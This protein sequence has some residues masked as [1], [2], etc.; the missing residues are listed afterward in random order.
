MLT[1]LAPSTYGRAADLLTGLDYQLSAGAVL[2]GAMPGAVFVDDPARPSAVFVH[3]PEGNFVG[4]DPTNDRFVTDLCA[5]LAAVFDAERDGDLVLSFD[6][7]GWQSVAAAI[8]PD[9]F[10]FKVT[11]R[12]YLYRG[13]RPE[14][15]PNLPPGYRI[16][17]IDAALLEHQQ[18]PDHVWEWIEG[19]WG[20][21]DAFLARGFGAA[22]V[23]GEA[24]VSWSLA[25]CIVAERA[26]I[27]IHTAPGH[28]RR[29][30]AVQVAAAAVALAFDRGL[31]EV[32][33]HCNDDNPGSYRTAESAGF[34]LARRYHFMAAGSARGM[35]E[36][37][38]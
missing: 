20:G 5:H 31:T 15:E 6:H 32:G 30:L 25:D 18:V 16:A 34:K 26:E 14:L 22:A 1:R 36:G 11:R 21:A 3:S 2:A 27:G 9:L 24:V 17:P 19:N 37:S 10:L 23:H 29:G 33:W 8:V 4:G 13:E 7:E 38:D 12:H 35:G 28:R